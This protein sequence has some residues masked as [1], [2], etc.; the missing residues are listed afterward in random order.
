MMKSHLNAPI[1]YYGCMQINI[2]D[3]YDHINFG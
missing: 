1:L 2:G 3:G